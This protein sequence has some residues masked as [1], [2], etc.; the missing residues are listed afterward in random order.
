[1]SLWAKLMGAKDA[2]NYGEKLK[3]S[4]TWKKQAIA[5]SALAGFLKAVFAFVPGLDTIDEQ[6]LN[7]LS[8]GGWGLFLAYNMYVHAATSDSVGLPSKR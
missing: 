7:Y 3:D 8:N 6:T 4:A 1:M 2:L 5:V